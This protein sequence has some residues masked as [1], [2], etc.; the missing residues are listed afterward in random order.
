VVSRTLEIGA[1]GNLTR[2]VEWN[3]S[4]YRTDLDDDIY[5]VSVSPERSYFQSIGKTMRQG[6]EMGVSGKA[7]K[8]DFR[9][10]YSL[11]DATFQSLF[12]MVSPH[13]S[14]AGND[15]RESNYQQ[16][17]VDAGNRMPGVP[18]NNLNA[19][20]GYQLTDQWRLGFSL[21]AH[22]GSF[23]RGNE[24]NAHSAGAASNL[25]VCD[26]MATVGNCDPDPITG[27]LQA[28]VVRQPLEIRRPDWKEPGRVPGYAVLN[29]QTSYDI[30]KGWS[31]TGI[32]NNVLDKKYFSAGRLGLNPF[33]PSVH[34]AI[35][36]SGWNYNSSEWLATQ[37]IAPGA[38]R[39]LWLTLRYEFGGAGKKG[40]TPDDN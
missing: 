17:Q 11:T 12:S 24:N 6:V 22:G 10:N 28:G 9:V 39:G 30:G 40:G 21:V 19:N 3:L 20:F 1:R 5:M 36:P 7:G 26:E 25:I 8:A 29:F 31:L 18:L 15:F 38:P 35:G 27:L 2:E 4:V 37:F 23:V 16:I 33:S 13:N 14:S 34:G 32:V